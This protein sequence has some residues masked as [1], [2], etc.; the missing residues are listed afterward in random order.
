METANRHL[1]SGQGWKWY[2]GLNVAS[3]MGNALAGVTP[4]NPHRKQPTA[5]NRRPLAATAE[6][7]PEAHESSSAAKGGAWIM[8]NPSDEADW[9]CLRRR[10]TRRRFTGLVAGGGLGPALS[11]YVSSAVRLFDRRQ[12][13]LIFMIVD[14][15][16]YADLRCYGQQRIQTPNLDRMAAEG[17]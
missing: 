2:D 16:G 12:P 4:R 8:K 1:M 14:D 6:R 7:T 10:L 15:L 13:N 3:R 9:S 17:W 11:R 5:K